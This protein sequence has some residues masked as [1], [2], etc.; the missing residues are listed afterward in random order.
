[1]SKKSITELHSIAKDAMAVVE[2]I[3]NGKFSLT[4][5]EVVRLSQ[6]KSYIDTLK[7]SAELQ[8]LWEN[9]TAGASSA[10]SIATVVSGGPSKPIKRMDEYS[11]NPKLT[12]VDK[13]GKPMKKSKVK[14]DA[15]VIEPVSNDETTAINNLKGVTGSQYTGTQVGNALNKAQSGAT[16]TT[17]DQKVLQ[18]ILSTVGNVVDDPNSANQFRSTAQRASAI[19]MAKVNAQKQQQAQQQ[20]NQ[21][22]ANPTNPNNPTTSSTLS[23]NPNSLGA[24]NN[25]GTTFKAGGGAQNPAQQQSNLESKSPKGKR[26]SETKSSLMNQY[27]NFKG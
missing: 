8:H 24:Q 6:I 2:Q 7:E 27:L 18:P 23:S 21:Q 17:T 3:K 1:M 26:I 19:N 5:A 4:E 22:A 15:G 11:T 13:S 14:E 16:L 20:K 10:G 12:P 25:I 9:A